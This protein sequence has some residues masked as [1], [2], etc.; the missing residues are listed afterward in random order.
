MKI[1]RA[2]AILSAALC[3]ILF[4]SCSSNTQAA[5]DPVVLSVA[6][7]TSI[8]KVI[9]KAQQGDVVLIEPGTYAGDLV[10]ATKNVTLRGQ[11]RNT[12]IIDGKYKQETGI[13]VA[14]DGVIV[15]NLTVQSFTH[16]GISIH[17]GY[18]DVTPAKVT[19]PKIIRRYGVAYVNSMN[20]GGHGISVSS[21]RNGTVT[22]TF[23]RANAGAGIRLETCNPCTA[24]INNNVGELNGI[25]IEAVN[26]SRNI[27]IHANTFSNNRTG[28]HVSTNEEE[29]NSPQSTSMIISNTASSNNADDA[30]TITPEL[31]GFGIVITGGTNNTV[32][33]NTSDKNDQ[34]GIALLDNNGF[35]PT[36]N[37]ITSNNSRSNGSPVG[38]DLAY[39]I[40]GQKTVMS[41]GNCFEG[42]SYS[43]SSVDRIEKTLPCT[44][45]GDGPF[46]SQGFKTFT[47]PEAPDYTSVSVVAQQQKNMPGKTTD[48]PGLLG[49]VKE[50]DFSDV[51]L[52]DA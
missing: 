37:K 36:G 14:A 47:I 12:V 50:P 22:E 51:T 52:P 10:I 40:A 17:G 9:D 4:A 43:S 7:G 15:E 49:N 20:N 44:G 45:A 5:H 34:V 24:D 27:Y 6:T 28:I 31:F 1:Q 11:D 21:S 32:T 29:L 39:I 42:N 48:I 41:S 18:K 13:N 30:P 26:A 3:A 2:L 38:F 33:N 23:T 46:P 35:L 16:D 25:G 8:Q 19:G